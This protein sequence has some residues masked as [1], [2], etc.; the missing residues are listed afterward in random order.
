MD[1]PSS[2]DIQATITFVHPLGD[3]ACVKGMEV[4]LI[5]AS[6]FPAGILPA[7]PGQTFDFTQVPAAAPNAI[8][9]GPLTTT[10]ARRNTWGEL[11]TRYR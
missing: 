3:T 5:Y 11:K 9:V 4:G 8:C 1:N 6:G 10:P 7:T 2:G